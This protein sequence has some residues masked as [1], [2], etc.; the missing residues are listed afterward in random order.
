MTLVESHMLA[1]ESQTNRVNEY[2]SFST[3]ITLLQDRLTLFILSVWNPPFG[4]P[5]SAPEVPS[6]IYESLSP[7]K[8]VGCNPPYRPRCL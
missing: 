3:I 5:V 6:L 7:I 1:K 2:D 8:L 4:N